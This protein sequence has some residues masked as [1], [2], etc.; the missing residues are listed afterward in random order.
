MQIINGILHGA[1]VWV[2]PLFL[3]LLSIGLLSMRHRHSSVIPYFFYPL[4]GLTAAGSIGGLLHDPL[5]WIVFGSAYTLGVAAAFIW[6]NGLIV[7]KTG[8]HMVL[9]GEWLTLLI[10]MV[11]FFSNFVN[12]MVES[13][14]PDVRQ[15]GAFT[16]GFACVIGIC[17]GSFTGRALRVITLGSRT[18]PA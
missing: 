16:V 8:M 2:R 7:E 4:F 13:M 1:P 15:I 9:R 12:G 3:V 5:K 14:A 11:V 18:A 17:A 10:L 6:Q